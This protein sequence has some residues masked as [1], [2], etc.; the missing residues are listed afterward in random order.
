MNANGTVQLQINPTTTRFIKSSDLV[1]A[2]GA[3]EA[4]PLDV[5]VDHL[6]ILDDDLRI[7]AQC[8]PFAS[9]VRAK[10]PATPAAGKPAQANGTPAKP[11]A[12]DS[13]SINGRL[14]EAQREMLVKLWKETPHATTDQIG[15][16]FE[17]R[18]G[19]SVSALTVQS[20]KP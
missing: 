9:A 12:T 3:K 6:I 18:S 11:A 4:K 20:Y 8:R 15:E 16:R 14:T 19:R 13:P 17:K 1:L 5:A 10:T 2:D 7:V